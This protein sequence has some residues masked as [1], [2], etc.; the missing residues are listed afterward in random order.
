LRPCDPAQRCE[1]DRGR[2]VS[3]AADGEELKSNISDTSGG[4]GRRGAPSPTKQPVCDRARQIADDPMQAR[5]SHTALQSVQFDRHTQGELQ[6]AAASSCGSSCLHC[7]Q[8]ASYEGACFRFS[9]RT[10]ELRHF[11]HPSTLCKA[12]FRHGSRRCGRLEASDGHYLSRDRQHGPLKP[13]GGR[14]AARVGLW[15]AARLAAIPKI[16]RLGET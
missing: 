4:G 14:H 13:A 1:P 3:L 11:L 8:P 15:N 5:P 2:A 16:P 12:S 9:S 7:G 10:Q 6:S